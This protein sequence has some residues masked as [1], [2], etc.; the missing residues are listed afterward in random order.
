MRAPSGAGRPS[1]LVAGSI[2]ADAGDTEVTIS[3][4][5]APSG[6]S[7]SYTRQLYRSTSSGSKGSAISGATSLPYTDTGLTNGTTY[8]YTLEVDDGSTTA[9]TSQ[10]S[11]TP[12]A[13]GGA[14]DILDDDFESYSLGAFQAQL[15]SS[16]WTEL[17]EPRDPTF[18]VNDP[19][20]ERGKVARL[21][22]STGA[23][24]ANDSNAAL[25]KKFGGNGQRN[26][27][28]GAWYLIPAD[29]VEGTEGWQRKLMYFKDV[30]ED[31][32]NHVV[33][34]SGF[35]SGNGSLSIP[36]R[37]I[38]NYLGSDVGGYTGIEIPIGEWFHL[39][40]QIVANT[41]TN[42][43]GMHRVWLDGTLVY[44]QAERFFHSSEGYGTFMFGQQLQSG[45]GDPAQD[46][47]RYLDHVTIS[48][49]R[50]GAS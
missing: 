4:G 15:G 49:T 19:L 23:G 36:I 32:G 40:T 8:Y 14:G 21:H 24:D 20:G 25:T 37:I 39:E 31:D 11:A 18:I 3:E 47:H 17:W 28:A 9:D 10:V 6:G 34:T 33:I 5:S 1:T 22:F 7:G 44:E 12:A 42:V 2:S 38:V 50:V 45:T 27:F 46:E 13:S 41:G 48:T 16:P 26:F 29:E 30:N 43:D 35:G